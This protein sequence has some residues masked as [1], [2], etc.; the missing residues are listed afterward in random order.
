MDNFIDKSFKKIVKFHIWGLSSI[1]FG[2]GRDFDY[3]S[4]DFYHF[5]TPYIDCSDDPDYDNIHV[6]EHD[7]VKDVRISEKYEFK[8]WL[9]EKESTEQQSL[10]LKS[11]YWVP[12]YMYRD[13]YFQFGK[14]WKSEI[15]KLCASKSIFE[16]YENFFKKSVS[17]NK[18]DKYPVNIDLNNRIKIGLK[19]IKGRPSPGSFAKSTKKIIWQTLADLPNHLADLPTSWQTF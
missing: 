6:I 19:T 14:S 13:W 11:D 16:F 12:E 18:Q 9:Y 5:I 4:D 10:L 17:L 2:T 7:M 1:Y 15:S 8:R 3:F